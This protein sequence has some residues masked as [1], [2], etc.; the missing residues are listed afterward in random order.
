MS[1]SEE[2]QAFI[3]AAIDVK[4]KADKKEAE[5]MKSKARR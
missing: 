1:L 3:W 5:K 4:A 2:E